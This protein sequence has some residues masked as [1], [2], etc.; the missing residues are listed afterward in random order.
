M[1]MEKTMNLSPKA[2]LISQ[3]L[4]QIFYNAVS[5]ERKHFGL[6]DLCNNIF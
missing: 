5:F 3:F 4:S 6:I 1:K 2:I